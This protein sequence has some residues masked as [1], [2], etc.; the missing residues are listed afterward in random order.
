MPTN[1]ELCDLFFAA[2]SRGDIDAVRAIYAPDAVIWHND[3]KA[4]QTPD[5]NLKV[6]GWVTRNI[7]DMRYEEVRRHETPTGF[8]EQ[9]VLRGVAPNGAPLEI[10]A[11]IVCEVR[12]GHITRLDEYLDSAQT[13]ALRS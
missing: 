11:C 4:E 1:L 13:A 10:P 7:K 2:I 3:E 9:H 12:D 5:R 6:L 8:V